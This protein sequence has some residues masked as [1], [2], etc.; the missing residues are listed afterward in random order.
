MPHLEL[1]AKVGRSGRA[2]A[3]SGLTNGASRQQQVSGE[4]MGWGEIY[5]HVKPQVLFCGTVAIRKPLRRWIISESA[6]HID[7]G[8]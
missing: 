5:R 7:V 8:L 6:A 4:V 2:F 1:G 3:T